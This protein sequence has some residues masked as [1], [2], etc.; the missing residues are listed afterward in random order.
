MNNTLLLGNDFGGS[1]TISSGTLNVNGG[2]VM[3][4]GNLQ[5]GTGLG[6]S[7]ISI[8]GGSLTV[9]GSLGTNAGPMG[10]LALTNGALTLT[11]PATPYPADG[12]AIVSNLVSA[13]SSVRLISAERRWP[14]GM[15]LSSNT[16]S[17]AE[18]CPRWAH[19]RRE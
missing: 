7:V 19:C 6:A 2:T 12:L 9:A 13:S 4:S 18:S 5:D 15:T 8:N 17:S 3:V 16:V 11:V 1:S 14:S 10:A